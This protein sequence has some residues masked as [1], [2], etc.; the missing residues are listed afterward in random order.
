MFF[1]GNQYE[2]LVCNVR[3]FIWSNGGEVLENMRITIYTPQA[4]AGLYQFNNPKK[5]EPE[6]AQILLNA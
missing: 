3:E 6:W 2:E 1:K 5:I 4:I